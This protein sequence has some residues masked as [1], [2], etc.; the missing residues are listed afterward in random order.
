[1]EL[2]KLYHS[3]LNSQWAIHYESVFNYTHVIQQFLDKRP[4]ALDVSLDASPK[5]VLTYMDESG[6]RYM[7]DFKNPDALP[8][9]AVAVI[10]VIGAF[11]K[12]GSYCDYGAEE[13]AAYMKMALANPKVVGAVLIGDSGG[14]AVNAISPYT[15]VLNARTK[16]VVALCDTCASAMYYVASHTDHIMASNNISA[17]F[18]SIGVMISLADIRPKLEA[19]GVKFHTVYAPESTHKNKAFELLLEG[20]YEMIQEE[21]LSPLAKNFQ[22]AVKAQRGNKLKADEVGVLTGKMFFT[23]DAIAVGLAD[24]K[25]NMQAA[26]EKVRELANDK[27]HMLKIAL[28]ANV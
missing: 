2:N 25:G 12:Y 26:Q 28:K 24:S 5:S 13:I 17:A 4:N 10:E 21:M 11:T 20:K 1:M 27:K 22:N 8:N 6:N 18:G 19:E 3:I 14:G 15:D 23:D 16:P 9:N 7:H